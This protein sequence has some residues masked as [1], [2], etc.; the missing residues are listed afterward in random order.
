MSK[1]VAE[2][3]LEPRLSV[4]VSTV[5]IPPSPKTHGDFGATGDSQS[6]LPG[7]GDIWK[8]E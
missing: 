8:D 4:F 1:P 2:E 6:S 3:G 7:V 5:P